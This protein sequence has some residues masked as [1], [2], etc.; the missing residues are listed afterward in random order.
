MVT[1]R[2]V[3]PHCVLAH[4]ARRAKTEEHARSHVT[5]HR[6][7]DVP[8]RNHASSYTCK[9]VDQESMLAP[10]HGQDIEERNGQQQWWTEVEERWRVIAMVLKKILLNL[11]ALYALTLGEAVPLLGADLR[12]IPA[13]EISII[14]SL[15]ILSSG[16]SLTLHPFM[17]GLVPFVQAQ[18]FLSITGALTG[19]KQYTFLPMEYR[20]SKEQLQT[21]N[22]QQKLQRMSAFLGLIIAF[23]LAAIFAGTLVACGACHPGQRLALIFSMV[24]GSCIHYSLA[25]NITAHGLGNGVSFVYLTSIASG[26]KMKWDAMMAQQLML[27]DFTGTVAI[28]AIL[29]CACIMMSALKYTLKLHPISV[30]IAAMGRGSEASVKGS[31]TYDINLCPNSTLVLM[32]VHLITGQLGGVLPVWAVWLLSVCSIVVGNMVDIGTTA[33]S[34]KNFFSQLNVSVNDVGPGDATEAYL[35]KV[36]LSLRLIGSVC[37]AL[38]YALSSVSEWY[39]A[40]VAGISI[41][42]IEVLIVV[43]TVTQSTHLVSRS[44]QESQRLR[45]VRE[46]LGI[47]TTPSSRFA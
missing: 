7:I 24:A 21:S 6:S 37:L 39:L 19:F 38:L 26:M 23:V 33:A 22:G 13:D 16:T 45:D 44:L 32:S 17:V 30:D 9:S 4:P 29:G 28:T 46:R 11:I 34:A 10:I 27:N 1:L 14:S 8:N 2:A 42:I 5:I 12:G 36:M 43:S 15:S 25:L 40:T 20:V 18:I 47:F 3:Q 35:R 41:S 31:T